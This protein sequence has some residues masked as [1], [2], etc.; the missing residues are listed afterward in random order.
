MLR[1][2]CQGRKLKKR[3][4]EGKLATAK[5]IAEFSV[6]FVVSEEL[7]KNYIDHLKHLSYCK[8]LQTQETARRSAR[9]K[10]PYGQNVFL[11]FH[12]LCNI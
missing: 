12:Y 2:I 7:V 8:S 9:L 1:A 11:G 10:C 4:A 5:E 3:F 6:A